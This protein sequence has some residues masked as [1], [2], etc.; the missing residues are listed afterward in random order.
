[1]FLFIKMGRGLSTIL[2]LILS[3]SFMTFAWYGHLKFGTP[4][5]LSNWGMFGLIV[6]SWLIA[7]FEDCAQVPA[8]RLG[9][10]QFGGPF[11]QKK[12]KIIQEVISLS[13]FIP[14]AMIV[15]NQP[16]KTN[17]IW[18]CLCLVGAVYFMFKN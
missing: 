9:F 8:N 17:Y 18:A 11:S 10:N 12:L 5:L 13:V 1:M 3:N 15:M 14:F 4:K 6:M 16:F 7:F 2:L